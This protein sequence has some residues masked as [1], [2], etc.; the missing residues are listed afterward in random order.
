MDNSGRYALMASH[1]KGEFYVDREYLE[2]LSAD[3]TFKDE[4]HESIVQLIDTGIK[5][6]DNRT[7]F[8]RQQ[9]PMYT[10]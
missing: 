4:G 6:L 5:Y 10:R 1:K 7:D 8:W 2:Q 9:K 3:D